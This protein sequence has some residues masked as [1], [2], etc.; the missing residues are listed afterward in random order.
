MSLPP[1][2]Q[3]FMDNLAFFPERQER[4]QALISVAEKYRAVPEEIASKPYDE[5]QR[6]KGC[7]SEAFAWVNGSPESVTLHFAVENP[8]GISAMALAAILKEGLDGEP[9]SSI[10]Q[11]PEDIVYDI[12]G[13]ELSM[14]K[15]M[16]LTNMV[17][18]VKAEAKAL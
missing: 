2:L 5:S 6:V 14:G 18:M 16:G 17:R 12:F 1:K 10:Q 15:T 4:I 8:Q 11:V 13:K 9:A 7:E 3:E